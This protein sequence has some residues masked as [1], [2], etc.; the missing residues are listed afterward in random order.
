MSFLLALVAAGQEAGARCRKK[1]IVIATTAV[2]TYSAILRTIRRIT[3]L[4]PSGNY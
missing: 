2:S 1:L 4:P 3:V